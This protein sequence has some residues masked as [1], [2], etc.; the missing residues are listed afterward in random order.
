MKI[1]YTFSNNLVRSFTLKAGDTFLD[2]NQHFLIC[3]YSEINKDSIVYELDLS[4][5]IFKGLGDRL[6]L[7]TNAEVN[8]NAT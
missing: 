6:V 5:G 2:N 8:I 7:K 3:C 4:T 1:N